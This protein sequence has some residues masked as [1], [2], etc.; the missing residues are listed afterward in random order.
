MSDTTISISN[1]GASYY[2]L[3]GELVQGS[4]TSVQ[5][6]DKLTEETSTGLISSSFSGLGSGSKL[7]LDLSNEISQDNV[8]A[9]NIS[10]ADS[11]ISLTQTAMNQLGS[12]ALNF[13]T[14]TDSLTGV[15]P[16][17]IDDV[18]GQ[19]K[20]ALQEVASLLDTTDAGNYIFA[21]EDTANPPV[22]N[23][24]EI[25]SSSFYTSINSAVTNELASGTDGYTIG[26]NTLTLATSNS[27]YSST[28]SSKRTTVTVLNNQQVSIGLLA[29]QNAAVTSSGTSTTGSYAL[30][31]MRALATLSSMSSSQVSDTGFAGLVADTR[32]SL[33]GAMTAMD[34]EEGILGDTQAQIDATGTILSA[35]TL[36]LTS[37]LS[38]LEDADL[39]SVASQLTAAQTQLTASYKLIAS[40]GTL[41]LVNYI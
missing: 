6:V 33:S 24:D 36:A 15:D 39:T 20:T 3:L 8:W 31:L 2:G 29:N 27:P 14:L 28:I 13:Y 32:S 4:E 11:T 7:S 22:P 16:S 19:A 10:Q 38:D 26:Q 34:D 25:T 23:P 9:H 30:D 1:A 35:T 5:Q 21:G 12:I 17:A 41:S 40:V 18:A 37:Q